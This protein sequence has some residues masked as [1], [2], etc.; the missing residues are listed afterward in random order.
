MRR[1]LLVLTLLILPVVR[2]GATD[3]P[4][5]H[6]NPRHLAFNRAETTLTRQNVKFLKQKW[7]GIA[8]DIVGFSSPAVGNGGGYFGST[9]GQLYVFNASGF[10]HSR[11][12]S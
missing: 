3:W 7:V 6:L 8:G 10:G 4:L 11:C 12:N 2:G 1:I 9:D 5:F